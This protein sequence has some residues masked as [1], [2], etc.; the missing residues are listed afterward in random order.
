MNNPEFKLEENL[1]EIQKIVDILDSGDIPLQ[2]QIEYFEK[3][4]QITKSC[5]EFL[6]NAEQKIIDI[7]K[8]FE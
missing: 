7:S 3:G 8:S 1:K 5:R 4:M 2:Q 6:T